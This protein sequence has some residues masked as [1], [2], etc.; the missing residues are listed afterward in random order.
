[1]LTGL[2]DQPEFSERNKV[3]FWSRVNPSDEIIH[4]PIVLR[5][6]SSVKGRIGPLWDRSQTVTP[7]L[8]GIDVA[9][10]VEW[11]DDV[12]NLLCYEPVG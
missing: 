3:L 11:T 12:E 4:S 8:F 1:M 10:F 2:P 6:N 9:S 7:A 5:P